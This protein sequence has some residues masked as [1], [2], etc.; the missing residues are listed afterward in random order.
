MFS[1]TSA[2]PRSMAPCSSNTARARDQFLGWTPRDL[3]AHD[4]AHGRELWRRMF[5]AR[6]LHVESDERRLDGSRMWVEGDY[7]CFYDAEGRITGHFGIQ[8]DVT[9]RKQAEEAL[10]RFNRRLRLLQQ[11]DRAILSAHSLR[12]NCAGRNSAHPR[13]C[14]VPA[15]Q[16]RGIRSG[17]R[18]GSHHWRL[19]AGRHTTGCWFRSPAGDLRQP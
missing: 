12:G 16:R 3:F 19:R 2:S 18:P 6:R 17:R 11:T 4:L 5:D 9:E 7:I 14:P 10:F 13:T 1:S 15:R 8:R